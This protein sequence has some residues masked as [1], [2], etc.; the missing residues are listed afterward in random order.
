M[1][2]PTITSFDSNT[3]E[4]SKNKL[5]TE[6]KELVNNPLLTSQS[7]NDHSKPKEY[8]KTYSPSLWLTGC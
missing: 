5:L 2:T 7:K 4:L 8:M 1:E 3:S 6:T